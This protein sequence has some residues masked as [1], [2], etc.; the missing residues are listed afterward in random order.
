MLEYSSHSQRRPRKTDI[1][2]CCV[3]CGLYRAAEPSQCEWPAIS[4]FF[5]NRLFQEPPGDIE[6]DDRKGPHF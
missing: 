4:L 3:Q 1:P 5:T 2:S 6:N